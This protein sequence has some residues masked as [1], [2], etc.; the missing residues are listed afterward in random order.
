VFEIVKNKKTKPY[1]L[2]IVVGF[3]AVFG[4]Y[5]L[6]NP[7]N[8][9]FPYNIVLFDFRS[10]SN[11]PLKIVLTFLVLLFG[12]CMSIAIVN[13]LWRI[14]GYVI[15]KIQGFSSVSLDEPMR[16]RKIV[17]YDP[18][19]IRGYFVWGGWGSCLLLLLV[20]SFIIQNSVLYPFFNV[21]YWV[22]LAVLLSFAPMILVP[23]EYQ[24]I[25]KK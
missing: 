21:E 6:G 11:I 7:L 2:G 15:F 16:L 1:S 4:S 13:C 10:I 5:A 9:T 20:Q 14:V 8:N 12:F 19:N 18:R 3:A 25:N 17:Y 22:G 23:K 24:I